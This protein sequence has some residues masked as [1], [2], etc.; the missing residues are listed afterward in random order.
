MNLK[1]IWRTL[2]AVLVLIIAPL[3]VISN[4]VNIKFVESQWYAVVAMTVV[5]LIALVVARENF[6]TN[7]MKLMEI[8]KNIFLG[9]SSILVSL[10]FFWCISVYYSDTTQYDFEWQPVAMAILS[11][12]SCIS[13]L[14]MAIVFFTGKNIFAKVPFFLFCPIYWFTLDMILF[15]SI[16]N[17]NNDIY[18]ICLTGFLA[19]FF[20]YYS[21]IFATSSDSNIIKKLLMT[22]VPCIGFNIIKSAPVFINYL[23]D[24]SSVKPVSLATCTMETLVVMY[25]IFVIINIKSQIDS[26]NNINNNQEITV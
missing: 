6:S 18:D 22:G 14:I 13:F 12:L 5:L 11:I 8:N 1:T 3:K 15:L 2:V 4:F 26:K 9:F 7:N 24:S 16:Q 23:K 17:D 10:S 19:L 25:I 20:V 21:Q